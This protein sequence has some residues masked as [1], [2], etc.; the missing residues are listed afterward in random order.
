MKMIQHPGNTEDDRG[1]CE[2]W[3]RKENGAPGEPY[4]WGSVTFIEPGCWFEK[5]FGLSVAG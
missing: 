1:A 2:R 4:L 3:I 5:G